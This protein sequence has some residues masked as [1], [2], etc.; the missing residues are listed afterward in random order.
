M[1]TSESGREEPEQAPGVAPCSQDGKQPVITHALF[2]SPVETRGRF[3]PKFSCC[4]STLTLLFFASHK[5][6]QKESVPLHPPPSPHALN[7]SSSDLSF[8]VCLACQTVY[9]SYLS[10]NPPESVVCGVHGEASER[11]NVNVADRKVPRTEVTTTP[12]QMVR[13]G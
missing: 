5:D 9:F 8:R 11:M 2:L 6:P 10:L 3:S 7:D 4:R 1:H 12:L 13:R